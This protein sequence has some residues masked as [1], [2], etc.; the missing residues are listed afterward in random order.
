MV[1]DVGIGNRAVSVDFGHSL[2]KA[3][4]AVIQE[5]GEAASGGNAVFAGLG[6]IEGQRLTQLAE[7]VLRDLGIVVKVGGL[8]GLLNNVSFHIVGGIQVEVAGL[9][10]FI[11]EA[12]GNTHQ[13]AEIAE[14][15]GSLAGGESV[16]GFY[17]LGELVAGIGIKFLDEHRGHQRC[18]GDFF[19][20]QSSVYGSSGDFR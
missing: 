18:G 6:H 4:V 12:G 14:L 15:I 10:F 9:T 11:G 13:H 3:S 20:A 17:C 19:F 16:G 2:S 1:D 8:L 7:D 5:S